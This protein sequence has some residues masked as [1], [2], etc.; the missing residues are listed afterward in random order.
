M[1]SLIVL[2]VGTFSQKIHVGLFGGVSAYEGDLVDK[3]FPKKVTN[4]VI[5][6][7]IN[8]ELMEQFMVRGGFTYSIIGGADRFSTNDSLIARNLAR[9]Q[10]DVPN[11]NLI[12]HPGVIISPRIAPEAHFL[13]GGGGSGRAAPGL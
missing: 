12:K 10:G 2:S 9:I 8:Y 11:A 6:V 7:S 4:G 3:V 13:R 1:G 5:G